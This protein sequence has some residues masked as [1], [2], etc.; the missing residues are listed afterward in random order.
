M[1]LRADDLALVQSLSS[2]SSAL[3]RLYKVV[4]V[5]LAASLGHPQ[6]SHEVLGEYSTVKPL[7][8]EAH[9]RLSSGLLSLN[10]RQRTSLDR[11][12]NGQRHYTATPTSTMAK[13]GRFSVVP[14][15]VPFFLPSILISSV[16][17][18]ILTRCRL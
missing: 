4:S 7:L 16:I 1:F 13:D 10:N 6:P 3:L 5:L 17:T 18:G 11:R 8:P 12:D 15:F 9:W 2:L 14:S